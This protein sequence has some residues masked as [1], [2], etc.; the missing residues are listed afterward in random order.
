M[1]ADYTQISYPKFRELL[2]QHGSDK[3]FL[4]VVQRSYP[5]I[6]AFQKFRDRWE[7]N[8][9]QNVLKDLNNI[10]TKQKGESKAEAYKHIAFVKG[11]T[12]SK[13]H[14]TLYPPTRDT[15]KGRGM[16]I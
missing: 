10:R 8:C 2:E 13:V 1:I 12:V 15:E 9:W 14:T 7:F 5:Q 4:E 16:R 6:K 11:C 3:L